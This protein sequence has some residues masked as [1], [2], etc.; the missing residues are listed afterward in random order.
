MTIMSE[1]I[2]EGV[3]PTLREMFTPYL[4]AILNFVVI[5][6]DGIGN[7]ITLPLR[8]KGTKKILL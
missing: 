6:L 1:S 5:F 8:L 7:Y 2:S 4:C 3:V